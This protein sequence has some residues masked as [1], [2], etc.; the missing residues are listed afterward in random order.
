MLKNDPYRYEPKK[1]GIIPPL[2]IS[3][4]YGWLVDNHMQFGPNSNEK[5]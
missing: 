4:R 5:K 2:P 1:I 3:K